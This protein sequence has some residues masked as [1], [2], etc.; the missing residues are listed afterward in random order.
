MLGY[1]GGDMEPETGLS[2]HGE[3]PVG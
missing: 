2:A 1:P 3:T